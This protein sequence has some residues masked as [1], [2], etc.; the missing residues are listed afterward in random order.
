MLGLSLGLGGAAVAT[1]PLAMYGVF[2]LFGFL[3]TGWVGVLANPVLAAGCGVLARLT[4]RLEPA[5]WWGTTAVVTLLGASGVL[6]FRVVEPAEL[7]RHMGYPEE[8]LA[9]F[10]GIDAA[11]VV[12][13]T[14]LL[15][16]GS[17]V[18]MAAIRKHFRRPA[19][20]A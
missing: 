8:Q 19:P 9:A 2:P 6:T 3:A 12:G 7:F 4:F 20:P 13:G 17:L 5:G 18:Y 11:V 16:L 15:T 10:Q 14:A 1:L